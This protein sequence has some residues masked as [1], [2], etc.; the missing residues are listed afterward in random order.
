MG[1]FTTRRRGAQS[2]VQAVAVREHAV[3]SQQSYADVG[4]N[5]SLSGLAWTQDRPQSWQSPGQI[6]GMEL[7]SLDAAP[8]LKATYC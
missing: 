8:A 4:S 7:D 3:A 1:G 2:V 5:K 6:L